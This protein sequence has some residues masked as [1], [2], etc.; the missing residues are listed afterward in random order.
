MKTRNQMLGNL[1][2]YYTIF[3]FYLN[4]IVSSSSYLHLQ[5]V[6]CEKEKALLMEVVEGWLTCN[7]FAISDCV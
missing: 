4:F 6:N 7:V 1:V 5:R 2:S 3:D